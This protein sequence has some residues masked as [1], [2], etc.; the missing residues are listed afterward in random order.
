MLPFDLLKCH[1]CLDLLQ[2]TAS[3]EPFFPI[4]SGRLELQLSGRNYITMNPLFCLFVCNR[5]DTVKGSLGQAPMLLVLLT[6]TQAI[7]SHPCQQMV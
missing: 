6:P 4:K 3:Q 7:S 2:S 1:Q 5:G